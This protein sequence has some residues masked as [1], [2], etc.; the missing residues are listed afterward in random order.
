MTSQIF[1]QKNE[2]ITSDRLVQKI[3]DKT[4]QM[5]SAEKEELLPFFLNKKGVYK[6]G[7]QP[8]QV[9]FSPDSKYIILPLLD[10]CGFEVFSVE[11]NKIIK[12]V[13]CPEAAKKGFAEGLFIPQ[14]SVFLVSQMTS[15]KLHEYSYPDFTFKRSI[16]TE[17]TWSKFI[18]YSEEKN[19][20]AVSNWTSNNISI[21]DYESGKVNCKLSTKAAPRGIAFLAA[22][23]ELLSLA[24]DGGQIERFDVNTELCLDSIAVKKS[25]MRHVVIDSGETFAYIS[26]MYNRKIYKLNLGLFKIVDKIEVFNNPNTI[27][28]RDNYLFVSCRGP[29]DPVNYTKRSPK[30]GKIY[31]I[32]CA[33]MEVLFTFEGGN[34]PTGLDISPDKSL[35]C[36]SNFQDANIE[37]YEI[38]PR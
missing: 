6:C 32:D 20:L 36:F 22:G 31:V 9:I 10:D 2:N 35:L 28:L 37:L 14:K 15:G 11:E 4:E 3:S 29:N 26:D 8:K 19:I 16:E 30:N 13:K 23:N 33:T 7:R 27:D 34:Q 12:K 38:I 5:D 24:F 1:S 25:S 17:G 21:I 18:A